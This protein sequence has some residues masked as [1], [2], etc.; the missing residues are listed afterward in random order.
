MYPSQE[1][2]APSKGV[3][4]GDNQ[5]RT[6]KMQYLGNS[7]SKSEESMRVGDDGRE[8]SQGSSTASLG[9]S[10]CRQSRREKGWPWEGPERGWKETNNLPDAS[11]PVERSLTVLY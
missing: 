1:A 10:Q 3:G 7:R 8:K 4:E 2:T 6:R 9:S 5:A 11:V